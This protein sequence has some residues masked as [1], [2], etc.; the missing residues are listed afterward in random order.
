VSDRGVHYR[1][2]VCVVLQG[3]SAL[4][5]ALSLRAVLRPPDRRR[6]DIDNVCKALLDSL[7]HGGA[8][9]DDSQIKRLVLELEDPTPGGRVD[10]VIEQVAT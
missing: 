9:V 10:V 5:G 8:Y 2:A 6:R 7:A 4:T 1:A 3:T